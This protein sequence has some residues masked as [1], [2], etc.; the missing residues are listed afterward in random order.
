MPR[1]GQNERFEQLYMAQLTSLLTTGGVPIKYDQDRAAI[2]T[3]LHLFVEGPGNDYLASQ[4][5]V[6]FQAKGKRTETLS[7]EQFDGASS[8]STS[9]EVDHLRYW[10]AAPEPVYLAVFIESKGVF[11]AE[12]VRVIVHRMW[13]AGDFYKATDAQTTVTL[14]LD[15]A[16][17]LDEPRIATMLAHRSMRI[18]GS[19][20]QGRPLGHRFDPLRSEL[21][22]ETREL[23]EAIVA[24]LI[25]EY[26][27]RDVTPKVPVSP[28]VS[29]VE[30]RFYDTMLWQSSAFAEFGTGPN[31]DFRDDPAV[32]SVQG[33]AIVVID[34][35]Q[36]R[37]HLSANERRTLLAEISKSEAP[38]VL[39]F[40]G[41]D[42]SSTG[43]TW[44]RF[45]R[46][47]V[48]PDR[49]SRVRMIGM[50]ALT[51]LVLVATMVYLDLAPALSFRTVNYRY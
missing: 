40:F 47:E 16:A 38:I 5:R 9:V 36:D 7:A 3:G 28:D 23:W 33:A 11:V 32:E 35:A 8:V 44:R 46:E 4:A 30:G 13:P 14:H 19:T 18:D 17:V 51:S 45:F 48:L 12:D 15:K 21:A 24:R 26:R 1:Q 39:F 31:D 22:V 34:G 50:E 43:G 20:F 37:S 42:L 41:K 29:V 25:S 49:P 10:Y 6:W 2:D 27:F